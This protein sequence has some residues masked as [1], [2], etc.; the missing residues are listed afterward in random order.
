VVINDVLLAYAGGVA[1]GIVAVTAWEFHY[2]GR[3]RELH[4]QPFHPDRC[5]GFASIGQLFF[6]SS[7]ILVVIVL[8]FGGWLLLGGF[9][10][11]KWSPAFDLSY[12]EFQPWL[13]GTLVGVGLVSIAVFFL[14]LLNIH[15]MMTVEAA[16][17]K[18]KVL[19]F[20]TEIEDLVRSLVESASS[21]K[22]EELDTSLTQ[23]ESLRKAYREYAGIPTWPV[24]FQTRWQFFTAQLALWISVLTLMDKIKTLS[25]SLM[26]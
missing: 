2:L 20:A 1:I 15:R 21:A 18:Q 7:I 24:D 19:P 5:A 23:I 16:E 12:Q 4:M 17:Y 10:Y 14:P 25:G 6:F 22:Y 26:R 11:K 13:A 9:L 8:F 3:T